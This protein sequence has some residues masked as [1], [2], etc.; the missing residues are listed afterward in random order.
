[1]KRS[2]KSRLPW[3]HLTFSKR[4]KEEPMNL[5]STQQS[6]LQD[7]LVRVDE[8]WNPKWALEDLRKMAA[9]VTGDADNLAGD[10]ALEALIRSHRLVTDALQNAEFEVLAI[11]ASYTKL[12]DFMTITDGDSIT[13]PL[14]IDTADSGKF[15]DNVGPLQGVTTESYELSKYSRDA[16]LDEFD[17]LAEAY[18][19][20]AEQADVAEAPPNQ[21]AEV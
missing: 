5:L 21:R 6:V 1:M 2:Q 20:L 15:A 10:P 17:N 7:M 18:R 16:I 8:G 14:A 4:R 13:V 3:R 12:I 9:Q 11:P 19:L